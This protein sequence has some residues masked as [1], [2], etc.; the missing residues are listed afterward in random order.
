MSGA[1]KIESMLDVGDELRIV[2]MSDGW[3]VT[4]PNGDEYGADLEDTINA[5][6]RQEYDE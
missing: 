6:A 5:V 4:G 2:R 3:H 1:T